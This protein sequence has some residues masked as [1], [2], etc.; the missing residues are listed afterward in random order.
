MSLG[1][2]LSESM[3]LKGHGLVLMGMGSLWERHL[4]PRK[5]KSHGKI[6]KMKRSLK[7]KREGI[8]TVILGRL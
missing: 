5:S 7:G 4:F 3:I 2:K 8:R 6:F 1:K